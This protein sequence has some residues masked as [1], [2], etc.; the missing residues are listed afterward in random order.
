[1]ARLVKQEREGDEEQSTLPEGY[2]DGELV[3]IV[4]CRRNILQA[5]HKSGIT[6]QNHL[7]ETAA[8]RTIESATDYFK[9]NFHLT[10]FDASALAGAVQQGQTQSG[11]HFHQY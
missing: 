11:R 10:I 4:E 6:N 5:L 1:M 2:F 9:S 8:G 3:T 7:K